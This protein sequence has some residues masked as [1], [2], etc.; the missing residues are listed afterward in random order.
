LEGKGERARK[1]EKE[2]GTK[3][4]TKKTGVERDREWRQKE[5]ERENARERECV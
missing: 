5:K 4:G 2:P 1:I 3:T